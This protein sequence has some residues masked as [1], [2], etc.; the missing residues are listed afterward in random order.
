MCVC[1]MNSWMFGTLLSWLQW[2][3][4]YVLIHVCERDVNSISSVLT[5]KKT[6]TNCMNQGF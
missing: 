2:F 4:L 1:E 6:F 3:F 5:A